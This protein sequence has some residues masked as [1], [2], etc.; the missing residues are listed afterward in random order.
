[1]SV[2]T[3]RNRFAVRMWVIPV[4]L[5]VLAGCA[6]PKRRSIPPTRKGAPYSRAVQVGDT[7]Y[8]AGDGVINPETGKPYD[9]PREEAHKLMRSFR[10]ALG[11]AGMTLDDLGTVTVYCSDLSLYETFNEVYRSY[12][13]KEF[14]ARAFVGAGDLLWGMRFEMQGIA[15]KR[16]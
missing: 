6:G 12:F 1:M 8:L 15:V 9:E 4:A 13:T 5:G 3:V 11:E 2:P 10:A 14:P 16:R 7:L